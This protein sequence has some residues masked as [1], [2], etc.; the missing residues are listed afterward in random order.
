MASQTTVDRGKATTRPAATAGKK[1]P[2]AGVIR[3]IEAAQAQ[4]RAHKAGRSLHDQ[5]LLDQSIA[6]LDVL[7]TSARGICKSQDLY[8]AALSSR[9][10]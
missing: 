8:P 4:L 6:Q 7:M 2:L 1:V 5:A 10:R 3:E 9:E